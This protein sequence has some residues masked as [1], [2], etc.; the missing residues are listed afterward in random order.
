M[1]SRTAR[2][3]LRLVTETLAIQFAICVKSKVESAL[4]RTMGYFALRHIGK[5][6]LQRDS[7]TSLVHRLDGISA[8][9]VS[10]ILDW[11]DACV[12]LFTLHEASVRAHWFRL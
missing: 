4:G 10:E 3:R 2:E 12:T 6:L 1:I 9:K 8:D 7:P 5:V 11:V